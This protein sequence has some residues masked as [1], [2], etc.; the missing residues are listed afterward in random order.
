MEELEKRLK[1]FEK[2]KADGRGRIK[3]RGTE[4]REL[5]K[6]EGRMI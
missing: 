5:K 2:N 6:E 4:E 1:D 3:E